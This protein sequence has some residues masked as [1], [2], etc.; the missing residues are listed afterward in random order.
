MSAPVRL[1]P[2]WCSPATHARTHQD[3]AYHCSSTRRVHRTRGGHFDVWVD[4]HDGDGETPDVV[5]GIVG[6]PDLKA[7]D[8]RQ[9]ARVL[10]AAAD[11][12]DGVAAGW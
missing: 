6:D 2:V 4:Q 7:L 5:I 3:T 1:D 8:A 9:L 10:L 11:I 12:A